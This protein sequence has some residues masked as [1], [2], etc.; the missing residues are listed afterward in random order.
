MDGWPI[1]SMI[2]VITRGQQSLCF[3]SKTGTVSV[4]SLTLSG[5]HH[6]LPSGRKT[7][8]LSSLIS[9]DTDPFQLIRE[10]MQSHARKGEDHHSE[11][12]GQSYQH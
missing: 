5:H 4:V 1:I 10:R 12:I 2:T 7:I 3:R 9:P 11:I 6:H 8:L